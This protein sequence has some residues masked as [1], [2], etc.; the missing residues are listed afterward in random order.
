MNI[1]SIDD[2]DFSNIND[3]SYF[4]NKFKSKYLVFEYKLITLPGFNY[5]IHYTYDNRFYKDSEI[6]IGNNGYP[7]LIDNFTNLDIPDIIDKYNLIDLKSS[8]RKE[9]FANGKGAKR[10]NV[11]KILGE[12]NELKI[13][14]FC[15]MWIFHMFDRA[16]ETYGINIVDFCLE[17][18][19]NIEIN[20]PD[21]S[22]QGFMLSKLCNLILHSKFH[23]TITIP[24][25]DYVRW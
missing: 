12:L 24:S 11:I 20:G 19:R 5:G 14:L 8:I 10:T 6:I 9:L 25:F 23:Y 15:V 1:I 2:I 21:S 7:N 4:N 13:H 22:F 3:I 17:T 18:K 16:I